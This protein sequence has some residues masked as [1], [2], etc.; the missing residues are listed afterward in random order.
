MEQDKRAEGQL[1]K[2]YDY[3]SNDLVGAAEFE[4]N[5]SRG[6]MR[7]DAP[8][9]SDYDETLLECG[10]PCNPKNPCEECEEYWDRMIKEGYWDERGWTKKGWREITK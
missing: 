4:R 2:N 5:R 10:K 3:Y 9:P 6:E 1:V 7:V 8:D